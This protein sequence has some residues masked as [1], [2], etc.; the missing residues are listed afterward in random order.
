MDCASCARTIE[1][2]L[3]TTPGV[4]EAHVNYAT[5]KATVTFNPSKIQQSQLEKAI[6]NTGYRVVKKT[7]FLRLF[8]K[9][10]DSEHHAGMVR[11]ELESLKG[12]S[13]LSFNY[14][15][16]EASL[17]Y[18]PE[19][20]T[21]HEIFE[22][23]K[24]AGHDSVERGE[25]SYEDREK[26]ARQA[27]LSELKN[28][29][30]ISVTLSLAILTL[31]YAPSLT[32]ALATIPV[33]WINVA[34]FLL[35]LPVQF[36]AGAQFHRGAIAATQHGTADMNTLISVGTNAAFLYSTAATFFPQFFMQA[37]VAP[38]IY[39][40]TAAVIITLILLG[41][42]FE[43]VAKGQTSEAIRRLIGLQPKTARV[44][45][46]GKEIDVP[47]EQ[48]EVGDVLRVRPGEKIAVDGVITE[49]SSAIDESMI[50]GESLPVDKQKGDVVIGATINKTGSFLMRATKVGKDTALAQIIRLVEEAQGSKA[51]VQ[52]L[53]DKV[54]AVFVPIV[55]VIAI[56]TFLVWFFFGPQPSFTRALVNFVAVLIIACPCAMG[57]ATP[58]AIMVGTGKGA[59]NGV[60]IRGGE[61]LE[62]LQKIDTIV[63]DKTGT[64]TKGKPSVTDVIAINGFSENQVLS[65]AASAE[66]ASEHP[67]AQAI[68]EMAKAKK[69]RLLE[70][71]K[72]QAVPGKGLEAIVDGKRIAVG[73]EKLML[74]EKA[75]ISVLAEEAARLAD[76][77]KT[78]FFVAVNG[79][80][81]GVLA[82]A[83][84]LKPYSR[85]AVAALE[86]MGIDVIMI[87]GDNAR[88]AKAIAKQAGITRVLAEVL[89][90]QKEKEI[91]RLRKQGKIVAMVGDG[92]NDAPALAA[93]DVGI[94][95]GSGTDV[96]MEAADVTLISGDLRNIITAIDL[97]KR[98]MR[99]IKENLFWAF[100][101]NVALIPVAAGVLYPFYGILLNPILAGGAMAFSSV[102]VVGNSLR[103]NSFKPKTFTGK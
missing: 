44:L 23:I 59:E 70:P 43:A 12:I 30:A 52:M 76:N 31:T 41:R 79:K 3:K 57:L 35:S 16:Q 103:L 5:E 6:E 7:Q 2:V 62:T 15:I 47:V 58:T 66:Q 95:I 27:E 90:E 75:S 69:L 25:E 13:K 18:D 50:T 65:L 85:E 102:S 101:Y 53:A 49:G 87:T 100:A 46:K 38:D 99:T 34:M 4:S 83:D 82:I 94:A 74:K 97:S 51:P 20:V 77:G 92:I 10:M 88:T 96:A 67:I 54:S 37:G 56:A 8:I 24:S 98:T 32:N 48:V 33:F 39:F 22:A 71:K 36:W 93:A 55:I 72:F 91:Q 81:A 60:L 42:Y 61:A 1:N 89:P 40:D 21:K 19:I 29:L 78:A 64:L 28:K 84:T 68:V 86:K 63:L 80:T 73:N 14:N 45:R 17:E 11:G 26:L 9:G